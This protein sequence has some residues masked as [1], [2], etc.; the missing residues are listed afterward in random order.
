MG[1][2]K[3]SLTKQKKKKQAKPDEYISPFLNSTSLEDKHTSFDLEEFLNQ[4]IFN[5]KKIN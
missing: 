3:I 1:I 2:K 4:G 5:N